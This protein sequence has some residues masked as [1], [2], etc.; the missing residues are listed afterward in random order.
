L[1]RLFCCNRGGDYGG[2]Y[3]QGGGC[4]LSRL[5]C[6]NR[7]GNGAGYGAYGYG[8]G[9]PYVIVAQNDSEASTQA[10]VVVRVP[11]NAKLLANGQETDLTGEQRVFRTPTLTPGQDFKYNMAIEVNVDGE[12]KTITKQITVRAGH[13]TNV[14]FTERAASE[15]TVTLP[16]KARLTVDGVDTRMTG[17]KHTFKTPELAKGQPFSYIFRAEIDRNGTMEVVSQEVKFKAG[18]SVN[19]DFVNTTASAK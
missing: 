7:G 18:E 16:A 2:G 10:E 6:C 3:G 14:D 13:R 1:S 12:T 8:Y 17:G 11:S 15:V 5:F 19:V 9:N 4:C